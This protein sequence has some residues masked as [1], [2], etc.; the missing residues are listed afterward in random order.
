MAAAFKYTATFADG[1]TIQ[2]KSDRF[3]SHAWRLTFT[4]NLG[5][6]IVWTGFASSAERAAK[7]AALPNPYYVGRHMSSAE[8]AAQKAKN[9][10]FAATCGAKT[11]IVTVNQ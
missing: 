9:A 5:T 10:Q 2:R 8:K 7:A 11:E 1:T 6:Q 3:Y 4:S